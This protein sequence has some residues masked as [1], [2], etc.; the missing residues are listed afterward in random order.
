MSEI[1]ITS[2]PLPATAAALARVALLGV[3][4]REPTADEIAAQVKDDPFLRWIAEPNYWNS[5]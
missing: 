4:G 2:R 3:L 5:K 1:K